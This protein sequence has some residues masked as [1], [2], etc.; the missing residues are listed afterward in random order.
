MTV[1]EIADTTQSND[2]KAL[3][4]SENTD[5]STIGKGML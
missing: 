4:T 3:V 5:E 2:I 1:K